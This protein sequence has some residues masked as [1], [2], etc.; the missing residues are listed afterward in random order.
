M[1]CFS[2]LKSTLALE[3]VKQFQDY[4]LSANHLRHGTD[5]VFMFPLCFMK[6]QS[7]KWNQ[8]KPSAEHPDYVNNA[9]CHMYK[10]QSCTDQHIIHQKTLQMI[11]KIHIR[12]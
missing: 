12:K 6:L 1:T 11:H 4:I 3:S 2:S 5:F 9:G 7:L 8:I 10:F